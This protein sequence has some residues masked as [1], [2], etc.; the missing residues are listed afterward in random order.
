MSAI[1]V[2]KM[3]I[4]DEKGNVY[5]PHTAA[6]I[7]AFDKSGT[8]ME[9]DNMQDGLK[10]LYNAI[11]EGGQMDKLMEAIIICTST[12]PGQQS[13]SVELS[14]P[15]LPPIV[16]NMVAGQTAFCVMGKNEY[17]VGLAS[18]LEADRE[19]VIVGYGEI[20][21]ISVSS[22]SW[23]MVKRVVT[24][25][26]IRQFGVTSNATNTTATNVGEIMVDLSSIPNYQNLTVAK[27]IQA[28]TRFDNF[29]GNGRL[30]E[31]GP[32]IYNMNY[33]SSAGILTASNAP[34]RINA[35]NYG[36]GSTMNV[37]S[38][39]IVTITTWELA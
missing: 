39:V 11:L 18:V 4:Q 19:K 35:G 36:T 30:A 27:N 31:A 12:D 20:K 1:T 15:G 16:Q 26:L 8:K 10:E 24:I 3:Q 9:S 6:E 13:A 21:K 38:E 2:N 34:A 33:D 23:Q 17:T 32:G 22:K 28:I 14:Q 29:V 25:A 5:L 37:Y 7:V